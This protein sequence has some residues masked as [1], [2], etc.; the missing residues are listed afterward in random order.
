MG[1]GYQEDLMTVPVTLLSAGSS[2]LIAVTAL[3]NYQGFAAI[4]GGSPAC[5]SR[6]RSA[7]SREWDRRTDAPRI[8]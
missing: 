8:V 4:T 1:G 5:D 3:P 2:V 7:K 6:R